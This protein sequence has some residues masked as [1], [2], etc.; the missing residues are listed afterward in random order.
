MKNW[1]RKKEMSVKCKNCNTTSDY[2]SYGTTSSDNTII[3]IKKCMCG[4][5]KQQI[6]WSKIMVA[7]YEDNILKNAIQVLD[8]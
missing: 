5:L 2:R 7:E 3:E 8:K 1:E 4:R 6:F